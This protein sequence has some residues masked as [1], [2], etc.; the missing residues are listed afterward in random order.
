MRPAIS[1]STLVGPFG[2]RAV[3]AVALT[4]LAVFIYV[5]NFTTFF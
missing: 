5:F 3:F 4:L 1:I 2:L